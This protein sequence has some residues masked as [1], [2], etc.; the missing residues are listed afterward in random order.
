ML[1]T[2]DDANDATRS[3]R[4]ENLKTLELKAKGATD[5]TI[6][7][8][9]RLIADTL[10]PIAGSDWTPVCPALFVNEKQLADLAKSKKVAPKASE[11]VIKG[12]APGR[13]PLCVLCI[14]PCDLCIECNFLPRLKEQVPQGDQDKFAANLNS[15][16]ATINTNHTAALGS[17][18]I[19]YC[20][21]ISR[22]GVRSTVLAQPGLG[23]LQGTVVDEFPGLEK[24]QYVIG[25]APH[26]KTPSDR[27]LLV[28][29]TNHVVF[30]TSGAAVY[31]T[32]LPMFS[33][34]LVLQR[35]LYEQTMQR[36]ALNPTSSDANW[37]DGIPISLEKHA[38]ASLPVAMDQ[39]INMFCTEAAI[40]NLWALLSLNEVPKPAHFPEVSLPAGLQQEIVPTDDRFCQMDKDVLVKVNTTLTAASFVQ[41]LRDRDMRPVIR[42]VDLKLRK[43]M[44]AI[45]SDFVKQNDEFAAANSRLLTSCVSKLRQVA[46][47]APGPNTKY[48]GET[49]DEGGGGDE[50]EGEREDE[51]DEEEEEE[52]NEDDEDG[53]LEGEDL[54][55]WQKKMEEKYNLNKMPTSTT[56]TAGSKLVNFVVQMFESKTQGQM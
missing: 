51:G 5:E 26:P 30:G 38:R 10:G 34:L 11:R 43:H 40:R 35:L 52:D 16:M 27:L 42:N 24:G 1:I 39:A 31:P 50:D 15:A 14:D 23:Y 37:K 13:I 2:K 56:K 9:C 4:E 17:F 6:Q 18:A 12:N 41:D 8:Q 28:M 54:D 45:I 46:M 25:L 19:L 55:A 53:N 3:Q 36:A 47:G 48:K 20:G 29:E 32:A 21:R 33:A 44:A 49:A 22:G 7:T